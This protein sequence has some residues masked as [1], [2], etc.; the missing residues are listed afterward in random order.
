[1]GICLADLRKK[2][3]RRIHF[4]DTDQIYLSLNECKLNLKVMNLVMKR[5]TFRFSFQEI[6]ND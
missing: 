6:R 3:G 5:E 4:C 1:M 2:E